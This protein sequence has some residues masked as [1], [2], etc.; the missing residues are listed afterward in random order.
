MSTTD[1]DVFNRTEGKAF[2][3][4]LL[5]L[6]A[7]AIATAVCVIWVDRPAAEFFDRHFPQAEWRLWIDRFIAPFDAAVLAALV[8]LLACGTW[9]IS[10]RRLAS[11]T[12]TLTLCSWAAMWA[13]AADI[14][15]KH[16]FGRG[17]IDPTYL[18]DG[19]YGFHFLNGS[20][21]WDCFPSGTASISSAVAAVLWIVTP[22][23]RWWGLLIVV[24]LCAGVLVTNYHWV[25]DVVAGV[26]IGLS[27]GWMTVRLLVDEHG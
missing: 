19:L 7:T 1:R 4:W 10:G 12:R 21:H 27:I 6:V 2:R 26:F 24:L 13:A 14:I 5:S 17:W 3:N 20:P 9:V 16:V 8:F 25:G 23:S 18:G 11:W 15:L 22:R